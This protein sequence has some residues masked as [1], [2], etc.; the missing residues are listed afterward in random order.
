MK[1]N[2]SPASGV[3]VLR[4]FLALAFCSLAGLLAIF[5]VAGVPAAFMRQAQEPPRDMPVP[6]GDPDDLNR[7]EI[8]WQNRLSYPT[9][10]FDPAW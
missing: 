10:V 2:P 4:I 9:G 7:M 1:Q 8:E 5:A 3:S 6:G